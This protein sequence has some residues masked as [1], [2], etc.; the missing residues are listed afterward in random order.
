MGAAKLVPIFLGY[1]MQYARCGAISDL[2][3][4]GPKWFCSTERGHYASAGGC[5]KEGNLFEAK[6]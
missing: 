6:K 4:G 1:A 3:D 5:G 2:V